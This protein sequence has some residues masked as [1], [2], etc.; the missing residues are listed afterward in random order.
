MK[1]FLVLSMILVGSSVF[2]DP[3]A[4]E[5][6]LPKAADIQAAASTKVDRE[7]SKSNN[8]ENEVWEAWE[9]C[10]KVRPSLSNSPTEIHFSK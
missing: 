2:A 7:K 4:H 1:R 9:S 5:A 6:G 3:A 10:S 8:S